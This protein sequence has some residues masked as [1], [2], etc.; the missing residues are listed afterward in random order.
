MIL[1]RS[2]ARASAVPLFV[3]ASNLALSSAEHSSA[4]ACLG[5]AQSF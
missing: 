4:G 1:A 5:I 3:M 2:T